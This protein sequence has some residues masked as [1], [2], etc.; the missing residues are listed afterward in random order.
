M[1]VRQL[2]ATEILQRSAEL[3]A[4]RQ[5]AG[6]PAASAGAGGA[7]PWREM[8]GEVAAGR[9][10]LLAAFDD[11]GRLAGSAQLALEVRARGRY[12]A[13][14]QLLIVRRGAPGRGIGAALLARLEQEARREGRKLLM[15][16]PGAGAVGWFAAEVIPGRLRRNT[17]PVP[18]TVN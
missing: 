15:P 3:T 17:R 4:L 9:Q 16:D 2:S 1:V 14:V 5:D 6:W 7:P 10:R 13:V 11:R 8:A 12:R 18:A